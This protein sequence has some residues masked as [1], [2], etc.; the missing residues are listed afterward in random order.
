MLLKV[1]GRKISAGH[2]YKIGLFFHI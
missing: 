1:H 2:L